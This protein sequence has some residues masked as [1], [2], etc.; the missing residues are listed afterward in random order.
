MIT[1]GV[2]ANIK[3]IT[4]DCELTALPA[5]GFRTRSPKDVN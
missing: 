2:H 5:V 4:R 1:L 3:N